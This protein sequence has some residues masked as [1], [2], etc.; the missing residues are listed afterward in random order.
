MVKSHKKASCDINAFSCMSF[1]KQKN[2]FVMALCPR[3]K[4]STISGQSHR[5]FHAK[6][7]H[8]VNVRT[9]I[10]PVRGLCYN[11]LCTLVRTP[12]IFHKIAREMSTDE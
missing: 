1:Q 6:E 7:Q 10:L 2:N 8:K 9:C 11:W 5:K 3:R 4:R 12:T